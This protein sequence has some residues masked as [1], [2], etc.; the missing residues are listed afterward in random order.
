MRAPRNV[1]K[2]NGH[3]SRRR[4]VVDNQCSKALCGCTPCRNTHPHTVWIQ[5]TMMEIRAVIVFLSFS[6]LSVT[7]RR[8]AVEAFIKMIS[9]CSVAMK[10]SIYHELV[11]NIESLSTIQQHLLQS[12]RFACRHSRCRRNVMHSTCTHNFLSLKFM[13]VIDPQ[14]YDTFKM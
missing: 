7:T 14:H 13:T 4:G 5:Q 9:S 3:K 1:A 8:V 2:K 12:W 11:G 6:K 10:V